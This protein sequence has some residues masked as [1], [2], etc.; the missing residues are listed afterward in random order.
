MFFDISNAFDSNPHVLLLQ[1]LSS[2]LP[3]ITRWIQSYLTHRTRDV[4]SRVPEGSVVGP[5]LSLIY[6]L[7]PAERSS[8]MWLWHCP[9]S[10]FSLNFIVSYSICASVDQNSLLLNTLKRCYVLFSRKTIPT[11]WSLI[12]IY[13]SLK[14]LRAHPRW[15]TWAKHLSS[16]NWTYSDIGYFYSGQ[17]SYLRMKVATYIC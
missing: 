10:S 1:M 3:Y 15:F 14:Q 8:S 12:A 13:H 4:V 9:I 11:L 5:L 2:T 16:T 7:S 6:M 17:T